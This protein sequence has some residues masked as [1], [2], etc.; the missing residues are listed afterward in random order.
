MFIPRIA[1]KIMEFIMAFLIIY[2]IILYSP[3]YWYMLKTIGR[4]A[5]L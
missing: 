1:Y 3:V 5:Y 2:I 4:Q